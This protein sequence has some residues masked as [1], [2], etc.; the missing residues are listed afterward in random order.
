MDNLSRITFGTWGLSEWDN[1]SQEYCKEICNLAYKKGIRSFDTA[2][3]YGNGKAE[4]FLSFLPRDCFIATKVPAKNKSEKLSEA[5]DSAWV[6]DFIDMSRNR[7]NRDSLDLVLLHNWDYSWNNYQPLI[8]LMADLKDKGLVNNWGIS[9]PFESPSNQ[10]NIFNESIIDFF[11]IHYNILQ[12]QNRKTIN[13]LK[14]KNKKVLLRSVLLHGFL[15]DSTNPPFTRK[16]SFEK[17]NLEKNKVRL[18]AG[19]NKKERLEFC[20]GNAYSTGADSIILGITKKEHIA[21]IE[22]YL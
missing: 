19:L 15:M 9:L 7:L 11:Q 6:R 16:Y 18:L 21:G 22:R 20:L 4:E 1:Y 17:Q 14:Q 12:Q 5:Y 3:V 13:Y 2:S 10:N 8:D